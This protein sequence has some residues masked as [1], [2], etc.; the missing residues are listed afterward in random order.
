MTPLVPKYHRCSTVFWGS[1]TVIGGAADKP[2]TETRLAN[3][4][5]RI[6]ACG[7]VPGAP[8]EAVSGFADAVLFISKTK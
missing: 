6:G 5:A 7:L 1:V 2:Q 4:R 3:Q 8:P